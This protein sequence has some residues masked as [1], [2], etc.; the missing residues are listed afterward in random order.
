MGGNYTGSKTSTAVTV[1]KATLAA[2]QNLNLTS[3]APGKVTATWEEVQNA[4]GYTV[5]LYKDGQA[6]GDPV[7]TTGTSCEFSIAEAGSYTVKVKA[8]G[9][10]NYA[11]SH[12]V[13]WEV[14][15]GNITITDNKFTMPAENV[16]IRAVFEHGLGA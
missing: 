6:D 12:F 10:D 8:N 13:D 16:E 5:Q 2:P 4:S 7:I 9:S 1:E 15:S 3:T 11:D 14:V